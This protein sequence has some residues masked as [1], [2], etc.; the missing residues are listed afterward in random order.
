MYD[1]RRLRKAILSC[2]ANKPIL[3]LVVFASLYGYSV[4]SKKLRLEKLKQSGQTSEKSISED[5][6]ETQNSNETV[7]WIP[8]KDGSKKIVIKHINGSQF[9]KDAVLF[10]K[11]G[12]FAR[13][14]RA[15]LCVLFPQWNCRAMHY[16]IIHTVLLTLRTYLS[17]VVAE[18]DGRIVRSLMSANAPDFFS[19]LLEWLALGIPACYTNSLIKYF[20]NKIALTFRTTLIRYIHDLYLGKNQ[21]YYKIGSLDG[22][23]EDIDHYIASD[24]TRFCLSAARLYS[25]LGKPFLDLSIFS[26]KLGRNLGSR[27]ALGI[28]LNYFVTAALLKSISPSFGK[29]AARETRLE[30]DYRNAHSRVI[31][32]AEEIAF[33]DGAGIEKQSL[34]HSFARLKHHIAKQI[35]TKAWYSVIENY[36]LKYSWSASGF[37][38][39]SVPVFFPDLIAASH[40]SLKKGTASGTI[41]DEPSKEHQNMGKFVTNK[42]IMLSV[43]DAGGRIMYSIKDLAELSSHTRRVFQLIAAL[44]RVRSGQFANL[45][46]EKDNQNLEFTMADVQGKFEI[47]TAGG[48]KFTNVPVVVPGH[49]C[50]MSNGELLLSP[51]T[52]E[53]NPQEHL[54]IVGSNG[55]GKSSIARLAAGMWP[56]YRGLLERSA[57]VSF[58]PQ[59]PYF[60]YG[61]LRDQVIYPHTH[62]E[63]LQNEDINSDERILRILERVNLKYLPER[64]GGLGAIKEWKDVLSGGEKQRL[65][66]ARILYT[67]PKFAVIDEGTSA[68]SADMEGQLYEECKKDDIT[69]LT[70]THR[71]SLLKYH[72]AKLEVGL[73]DYNTEWSYETVSKKGWQSLDTE[74]AQLEK[75]L[76]EVPTLKVRRQEIANEL[77]V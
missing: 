6:L 33:Y 5:E 16:L 14:A 52:F 35:K 73:G 44:F 22:E 9:D 41:E 69:L 45:K 29:L 40:A 42:R 27:A 12:S 75:F 65:M 39:A 68:V 34:S 23:L 20:E 21:E 77:S 60:S 64:E 70:I 24:V 58:L 56:I 48:I 53:V 61:T 57:D 38:F 28:F 15:I 26:V 54:L 7:L 71:I 13:E 49:G 31:T 67:S 62:H 17:L 46:S 36:V 4:K 55:T 72:S 43:S 19:G 3:I 30:G 8:Y 74:I 59:R 66:F 51:L 76:A 63:M 50:D 11:G 2:T 10:E 1:R 18:L 37:L 25:S 47:T 32:N